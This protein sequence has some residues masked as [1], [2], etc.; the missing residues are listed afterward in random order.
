MWR[1]RLGLLGIRKRGGRFERQ[2]KP[3]YG[4]EDYSG[5]A[6]KTLVSMVLAYYYRQQSSDVRCFIYSGQPHMK[7]PKGH[8]LDPQPRRDD[9]P[10][11]YGREHHCE[12]CKCFYQVDTNG[13]IV[14][15]PV[16][17]ATPAEEEAYSARISNT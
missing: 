13:H 9:L 2:S 1:Y 3:G 8:R 16:P 17:E 10:W 14:S 12:Q 6:N 5:R 11:W 4:D 15:S 7:C